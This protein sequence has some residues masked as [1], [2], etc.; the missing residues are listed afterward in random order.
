MRLHEA[1]DEVRDKWNGH[2]KVRRLGWTHADRV[3]IRGPRDSYGG[4]EL[5]WETGERVSLFC[6]NDLASDD[7][8][9]EGDDL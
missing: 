6:Y 4:G 2:A 9:I 3:R 8:T 7:W 5:Y 1:L